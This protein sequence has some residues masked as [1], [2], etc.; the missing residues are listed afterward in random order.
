MMSKERNAASANQKQVNV[1]FKESV[2]ACTLIEVQT[3][4]DIIFLHLTGV[5]LSA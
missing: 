4:T 5:K 3:N 1:A 2:T